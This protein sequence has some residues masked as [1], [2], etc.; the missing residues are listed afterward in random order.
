MASNVACVSALAMLELRDRE[1]DELFWGP[2]AAAEL[3]SEGPGGAGLVGEKAGS[4]VGVRSPP[5]AALSGSP[6]L[7]SRARFGDLRKR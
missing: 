2:V 6:E 3:G 7:A 4:E 5:L 1:N